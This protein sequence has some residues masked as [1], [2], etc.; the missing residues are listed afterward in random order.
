[1]LETPQ[2][3]LMV[4]VPLVKDDGTLEVY[5][6]FRVQHNN[7]RGPFKGGFRFHPSVDLDEVR[8]LAALMTWK[9]AAVNIPYGGGKGGVAVDPFTLN[10]RELKQLTRTLL[11]DL[12]IIVKN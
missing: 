11:I 5:S 6:G 4:Q 8:G 1:M 12:S 9:C 7:A 10:K 3:E 2:R